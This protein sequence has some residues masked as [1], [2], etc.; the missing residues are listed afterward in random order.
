MTETIQTESETA[1]TD[2]SASIHAHNDLVTVEALCLLSFDGDPD[3]EGSECYAPADF[4]LGAHNA[5][6]GLEGPLLDGDG[7]EI[8]IFGSQF[9]CTKIAAEGLVRAKIVKLV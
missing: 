2:L 7:N 3:T 6:N 8:A 9:T 4:D 1:P 5:A